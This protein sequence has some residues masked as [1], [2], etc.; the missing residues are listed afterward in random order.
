MIKESTITKLTEM[1]LS[2]MAE[3]YRMQL[4]NK[5]FRELTFDE[6]F[7]MRVDEEYASRKSNRLN[8]LIKN[9]ELEQS[10]ACIAGIDFQSGR[11]LNKNLILKL[12]KEN[13][14]RTFWLNRMEWEPW[15]LF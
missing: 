9:A 14:S 2:T 13:V 3:S 5:E 11:K 12:W 6:R 7:G 15:R 10:E 4:E 1:H 8:R